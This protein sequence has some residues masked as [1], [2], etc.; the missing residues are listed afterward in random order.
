MV[1][2]EAQIWRYWEWRR[3]VRGCV[4]KMVVCASIGSQ[5]ILWFPEIH[6]HNGGRLLPR[7]GLT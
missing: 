4:V 7:E 3:L 1:L 5:I 2:D 6:N